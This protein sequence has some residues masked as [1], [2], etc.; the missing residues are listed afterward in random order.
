MSDDPSKRG[1][2]DRSKVSKQYFEQYYFVQK[3]HISPQQL[4][5]AINTVGNSRQKITKYLIDNKVIKKK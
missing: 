2:P 5:G 4:M 1:K 3:Y